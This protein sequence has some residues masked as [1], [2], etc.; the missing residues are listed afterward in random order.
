MEVL[1]KA[2][3]AHLRKAKDPLYHPDHGLDLGAHLGFD[4]IPR[5]RHLVDRS[6][7]PVLAV[8]EVLRSRGTG[9][10]GTAT[11]CRPGC[12][13]LASLSSGA[14]RRSARRSWQQRHLDP[15]RKSH[16]PIAALALYRPGSRAVPSKTSYSL[17]SSFRSKWVPL[18][19]VHATL[20]MQ[21]TS[22][23]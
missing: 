19:R 16:R 3:V 1:G 22:L 12:P 9:P 6:T 2:T 18:Q 14:G 20:G 7:A 17:R 21:I 4:S 11:Q 10:D 23:Q 13:I 5:V 15:N 8:R